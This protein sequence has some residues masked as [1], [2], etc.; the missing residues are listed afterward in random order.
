MGILC[1]RSVINLRFISLWL[2]KMSCYK[3]TLCKAHSVSS[4]DCCIYLLSIDFSFG[5]RCSTV[6]GGQRSWMQE[7]VADAESL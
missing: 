1:L 5:W 3:G 6:T 2:A 4:S 7:R